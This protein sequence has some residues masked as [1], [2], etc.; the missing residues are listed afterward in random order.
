MAKPAVKKTPSGAEPSEVPV[1]QGQ[2]LAFST[3][4]SNPP[5]QSGTTR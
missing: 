5:C 1:P 4:S 2:E 3:G